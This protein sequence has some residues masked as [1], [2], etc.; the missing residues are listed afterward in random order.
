MFCTA[1]SV[2]G[3]CLPVPQSTAKAPKVSMGR[4][5]CAGMAMLFGALVAVSP[6]FFE[7]LGSGTWDYMADPDERWCYL[8]TISHAMEAH[9]WKLGDPALRAGGVCLYPWLQFVPFIGIAK[10]FHAGPLGVL[11]IWRIWAG[12]SLGLVTYL[13]GREILGKGVA[14][15]WLAMVCVAD[16]G[17]VAGRPLERSII[18]VID[19]LRGN[20]RETVEGWVP[21]FLQYRMIT[22]GVSWFVLGLFTLLLVKARR[23]WTPRRAAWA[24]VVF[25]LLFY[26]YFYYWT[27]AGAALLLLCALDWSRWRWY[28]AVGLGG[29]LIG[30]PALLANARANHTQADGWLLRLDL[31]RKI[32][33][34]EELLIPKVAIAYWIGAGW[35][36]WRRHRDLLPLWCLATAGLALMNHQLL[37]GLQIQ[38]SHYEYVWGAS[39][40]ITVYLLAIRE[41]RMAFPGRT[42]PTGAAVGV[43]GFLCLSAIYFRSA[44]HQLNSGIRRNQASLAAYKE[45]RRGAPVLIPGEVIGG[46]PEFTDF[47]AILEGQRTLVGSVSLSHS[48][49]NQEWTERR[50]LDLLVRGATSEGAAREADFYNGSHY[51]AVRLAPAEREAELS[52]RRAQGEVILGNIEVELERFGVRYVAINSAAKSPVFQLP[53][54]RRLAV[55]NRWQ[56]WERVQ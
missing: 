41:M 25:G 45:E 10:L 15:L 27:A 47:A 50:L 51:L 3:Y 13:L 4:A 18:R 17:L 26:I 54:W 36:V 20:T 19:L 46:E 24:S 37:T 8:P 32:G 5:V 23:E 39:L 38:N 33:H 44:E 55:G 11:M 30:L 14:A 49:S 1:V 6:H 48:V 29:G 16:Q 35:L 40:S 22:P 53:H 28:F 2:A 7:W 42:W 31:F 12:A 21:F 43:A 9:P 34:F 52:R 56:I